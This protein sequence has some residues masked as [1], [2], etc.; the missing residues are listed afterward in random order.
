MAVPVSFAILAA[1]LQVGASS[2][3]ANTECSASE[4][5]STGCTAA[6]TEDAVVIEVVV[7]APG[8]PGTPGEPW[9][10]ADDGSIDNDAGVGQEASPCLPA[11]NGRC[12][13]FL[14][15]RL[16]P[17]TPVVDAA[18][19]I[20][21]ADIASFRP[22]SGVAGM[23][24]NGWMVVGLDTNFFG[25]SETQVVGGTLLGAPASVR[26]T[27]VGWRWNY[28]DGT[29]AT[30]SSAG[31]RWAAQGV[32]EF[33]ATSGS[34]IYRAPGTYVIDLTTVFMAEYSFGAG[35]WNAINGSLAVPANRLTAV[36]GGATTVLVELECT[37]NPRGPGC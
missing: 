7:E 10:E 4:Q 14:P 6:V 28:G 5:I 21:L 18:Q 9:I 19:P 16:A 8:A 29:S 22:A 27:P 32:A 31:G 26:F 36:A 12:K 15:P 17:G 35:S 34:H 24:P 30:L 1:L 13:G 23:E 33:D 25:S 2:A 37:V 20:T 11:P 3:S